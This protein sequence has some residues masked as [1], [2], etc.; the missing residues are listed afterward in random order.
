MDRNKPRYQGKIEPNAHL[1]TVP[2]DGQ[3]LYKVMRIEDLLRSITG[4]YLHFNRV[5]SYIDFHDADPD[6]GRQLPND[7]HDNEK[8]GFKNAPEFT[9]A[10]YYD[11]SRARTYACCFS[12]ENSDIIWG[13]Y[14]NDGTKGKACVVFEFGKLRTMLNET[15]RLGTAAL[16]YNGVKCDQVFD[17][18]YGIVK[19]VERSVFKGNT[20]RLLNPIK[21]TY[22]KDRGKYSEEK[23]FRISLSSSGFGQ[24]ALDNGSIM[25]FLPALSLYFDFR[26]AIKKGAIVQLQYKSASNDLLMEKLPQFGI[27]PNF[28]TE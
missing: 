27:V 10:K 1:L 16:L 26:D 18:N 17:L 2:P 22:M 8:I 25:K 14:E 13:R 5:D 21:Y 12:L 19:Y 28:L 23:E 4:N 6:D 3:L 9:A 7:L 24:F 11:Q 20:Q 15:L